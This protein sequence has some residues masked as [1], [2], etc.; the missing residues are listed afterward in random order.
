MENLKQHSKE[1]HDFHLNCQINNSTF[2]L[3]TH[4]AYN[5]LRTSHFVIK[6]AKLAIC[7]LQTPTH[8]VNALRFKSEEWIDHENQIN[9]KQLS[10]ARIGFQWKWLR[11][12]FKI[13]LDIVCICDVYARSSV[14]R[15]RVG[16]S[17]LF[18]CYLRCFLAQ[19][20]ITCTREQKTG[21]V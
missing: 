17:F 20:P 8:N 19:K 14:S 12:S 4:T 18:S 6:L 1:K 3:R 11:A 10:K 5:D 9:W 7:Q 16:F 15:W 13:Q 21:K 2:V